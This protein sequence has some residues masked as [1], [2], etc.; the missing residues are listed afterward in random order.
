MLQSAMKREKPPFKKK[1]KKRET[2]HR[3]TEWQ[4]SM[5]T[6]DGRTSTQ[7]FQ[8]FNASLQISEQPQ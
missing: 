6:V 3:M 8:I 2:P 4:S 1:K 7:G 5:P